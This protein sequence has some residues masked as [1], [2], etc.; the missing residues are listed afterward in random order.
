MSSIDDLIRERLRKLRADDSPNS[1]LPSSSTQGDQLPKPNKATAA[2]QVEDLL[3]QLAA[4]SHLE[5]KDKKS[6]G[7]IDTVIRFRLE[8][9]KSR[10]GCNF[11][12]QSIPLVS[13][14]N[15]SDDIH[16]E[17]FFNKSSCS[18]LLDLHSDTNSEQSCGETSGSE[19]LDNFCVICDKKPTLI[20]LGCDKDLYCNSCYKQFHSSGERH[21]TVPYSNKTS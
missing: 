9:L 3:S 1:D 5:A 8:K 6:E 7:D 17:D 10:E 20:C 15:K 18:E 13:S 14:E 4:E 21:K 16:D 2:E 12:H 19:D 11:S